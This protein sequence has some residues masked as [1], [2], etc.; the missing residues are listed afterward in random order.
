MNANK[1]YPSD[2][3]KTLN[4]LTSRNKSETNPSCIISEDKPVTDQK[5]IA[6]ILNDYFTSTATKLADKIKST[7]QPKQ[8][9]PATDLPY[10]LEFEKVDESFVFR[11]LSF[12]K[13]NKV[14]SAS[15]RSMQNYQKIQLLQLHLIQR[16]FSMPRSSHKHF[17][18]CGKK[19][20]LFSSSKPTT[21]Q[22]LTATDLSLFYLS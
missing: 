20:K 14:T 22:H 11:E 19:E 7:Y 4:E 8:P 3:W 12:L 13:T 9:P 1:D 21:R 16:R 6:A 5:S 17:Q 15:I 2:L 18:I 10:S